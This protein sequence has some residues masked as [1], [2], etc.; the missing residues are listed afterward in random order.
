VVQLMIP[1]AGRRRRATHE[2]RR[3]ER[4]EAQTDRASIPRQAV[5]DRIMVLNPTAQQTYLDA[6]ADRSLRHYLEHLESAGTGRGTRWERPGD[7]P[8]I[9]V[10]ESAE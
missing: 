2:G 7:S 9:V 4:P 8:A 3:P 6:F 5:L 10:R 1:Q